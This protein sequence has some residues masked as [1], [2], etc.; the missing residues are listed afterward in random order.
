MKKF[1]QNKIT[2]LLLLF[3]IASLVIVFCFQ[4]VS[5]DQNHAMAMDSHSSSRNMMPCCGDDFGHLATY[6]LPTIK[7][8]LQLVSLMLVIIPLTLILVTDK[9]SN[10]SYS[11][12][13]PPG[14]DLLLTVVKRE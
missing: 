11:L 2:K 5:A 7:S 10:F 14:P 13:A 4:I 8:M 9:F 3:I 1:F 12:L 6:D